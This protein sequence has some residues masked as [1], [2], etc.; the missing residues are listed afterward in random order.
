[1]ES[2][3]LTPSRDRSWSILSAVAC[4]LL[5]GEPVSIIDGEGGN[6]S[7]LS[8]GD[9]EEEAPVTDEGTPLSPVKNTLDERHTANTATLVRQMKS[10]HNAPGAEGEPTSL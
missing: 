2:T 8:A 1:M 4:S 3:G 5:G 6:E 10:A 7:K 9:T